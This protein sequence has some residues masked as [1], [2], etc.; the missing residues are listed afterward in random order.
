MQDLQKK[1]ID[2]IR[3]YQSPN[4]AYVA[5][6]NFEQYSYCWLRDGT[7]IAYAMDRSGAHESALAF[8]RWVHGVILSQAGRIERIIELVKSG[9]VPDHREMPP[10]RY[11]LDGA[12][13]DDEWTNFQLDGYGAWLWGLA[14]HAR[15]TGSDSIVSDMEKTIDVTID[16]LVH[17]WQMPNYDC[18]EEFGDRVHPATLACIWGGLTAINQYLNRTDVRSAAS[19]IRDFI[20]SRCVGTHNSCSSRFV[21]S[22]GNDS[23]DASLLWITVPFGVVDPHNPIAR[24]TVAEIERRLYHGG[25]HRYP[26]DTYYGGGEWPLLA[27]WL[28]W[29]YCRAGEPRRAE[30][31]LKW[32]ESCANEAG[33]IP[34]QINVHV[35][36]P[37]HYSAWC[38]RWGPVA[39]PLL[40]SSAMYLVLCAELCEARSCAMEVE[41]GER[42]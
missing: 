40:W 20:L 18:W 39:T 21:K 33:E 8:Y 17:C 3:R 13:N 6:P 15:I 10:T 31:I 29:H 2:I 23:I 27:C 42:R 30:P 1:S 9:H 24:N 4:G 35:N 19:A 41:P 34:E 38:K 37:D 11:T 22:I 28:G 32:V 7:F 25:V 26:E 5:C 14:E 36:D 12:V 16:Y